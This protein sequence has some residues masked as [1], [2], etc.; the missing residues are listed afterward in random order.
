MT[1]KRPYLDKQ[2]PAIYKAIGEVSNKVQEANKAAAIEDTLS[3]LINVRVSQ[4]NACNAC[5]SIHLPLA[6]KAGVSDIKLDLLPAWQDSTVYNKR[7]RAALRLAEALTFPQEGRAALSGPALTQAIAEAAE[8][9]N[10][11]ELA[12]IEW[13]TININ[14][15]NRVSIASNHPPVTRNYKQ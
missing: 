7:E 9:F 5:M 4:M 6:R 12:A 8:V 11:E 3:E 15:F 2:Q 14:T 13:T 1:N 10:E